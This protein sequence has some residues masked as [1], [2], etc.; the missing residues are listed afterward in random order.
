MDL[1]DLKPAPKP[2]EG[3]RRWAD[4]LGRLGTAAAQPEEPDS[5]E[6]EEAIRAVEPPEPQREE[7]KEPPPPE[8]KPEKK[9][10]RKK[11]KPP[12]PAAIKGEEKPEKQEKQKK[13]SAGKDEPSLLEWVYIEVYYIGI[14]LMRDMH[15]LRRE[16]ERLMGWSAPTFRTPPFSPTGNWPGSP[17][18]CSRTSGRPAGAKGAWAKRRGFGGSTSG[19]WAGR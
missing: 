4:I 8:Q 3:K 17:A 15:L 1:E 19:P 2:R 6:L 11:E 10:R 5:P 7:A 16:W 9:E 13:P 18:G 12:R 14:Q